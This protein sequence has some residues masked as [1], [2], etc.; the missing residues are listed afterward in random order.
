M[1]ASS[2][3]TGHATITFSQGGVQPPV[4]LVTSLSGWATLEMDVQHEKTDT[5][6]FV[7]TKHFPD[8][9][10]GRYQ[11][12]L[13][14]GD[15][16]WVV[17]ESKESEMDQHGNRNN[18]IHV[19]AI[20]TRAIADAPLSKD[21][22]SSATHQY[23]F[24][25]GSD[26][27]KDSSI[28]QDHFPI[29]PRP[30]VTANV[31]PP[32]PPELPS[33]GAERLVVAPESP[34]KSESSAGDAAP[35][36]RHESMQA[37]EPPASLETLGEDSA[38][39]ST[40]HT[41]SSNTINTPSELGDERDFN[42]LGHDPLLP[43]EISFEGSNG[44]LNSNEDHEGNETHQAPLLPHEA[45]FVN[46]ATGTGDDI[47][48]ENEFDRAPLLFHEAELA[49][50]VESES[51]TKSDE[52]EADD[53]LEPKHYGPYDD[54][55]NDHVQ[56][57]TNDVPLLPHERDSAADS[58]AG[59]DEGFSFHNQPTFGYETDTAQELFGGSGR[60]NIF[61]ARTNS[62]SLPHRLPRSD[63]EDEDLD[64]PSLERFPT[65]RAQ[66]LER[67]A[68]IGL[69]LPED[70]S[71]HN[72]HHS[73]PLSVLSQACS[74][75]DLAP[76]KSYISLA[77]VPESDFSDEEGDGD[78]ES[79]PSPVS[80]GGHRQSRAHSGFVRDSNATPMP[81]ES[82]QL[83]FIV[84]DESEQREEMFEEQNQRGT[85]PSDMENVGKTD[86]ASDTAVLSSLGD[87]IATPAR[88]MRPLTPPR[89]PER[90][91]NAKAVHP[92]ANLDAQLRERRKQVEG[93]H[94]SAEASTSKNDPTDKETSTLA[95]SLV[96]QP[97]RFLSACL[98]DRKR[99]SAYV[100]V[101]GASAAAYYFFTLA[102]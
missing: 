3:T 66:I 27:R 9:S 17:D 43:H 10:E 68:T 53:V 34:I 55:E 15:D 93:G 54:D 31:E 14:I 79:L 8:V 97:S 11:Y 12:K 71:V 91:I 101:L 19:T 83:G 51:R 30:P 63:A 60:A 52:G 86:G 44:F 73:P 65:N 74:S 56:D 72:Q 84:E 61:R 25:K 69:H 4:Y 94:R 1:S 20:P 37:N 75:V 38:E 62:S 50:D 6:D 5:G 28:E 21:L 45:R 24:D 16:H 23:D 58:K 81:T 80:L 96:Q 98:G 49:V 87:A 2:A 99:A 13:R 47:D 85:E 90:E 48:G 77:S 102:S 67:V 18:V 46:D 41:S 26:N 95:S 76:V 57:D 36:F 22:S 29:A 70:E 32:N 40:D 92:V 88:L 33:L 7:F 39:S 78:V 35:L 42:R 82:K 64:D 89:T 100:M 59:S